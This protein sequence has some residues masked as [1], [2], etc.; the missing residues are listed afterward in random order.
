MA[1][2]GSRPGHPRYQREVPEPL[3]RNLQ[4]ALVPRTVT[5]TLSRVDLAVQRGQ[6][7]QGIE[8]LVVDRRL[9]ITAES[10]LRSAPAGGR[11]LSGPLSGSS[12]GSLFGSLLRRG[13]Y[14]HRLSAPLHPHSDFR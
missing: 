10:A 1:D 8:V 6:F 3:Y 2:P 11:S 5:G 9:A 12:S 7:P 13:C 14:F 4:L